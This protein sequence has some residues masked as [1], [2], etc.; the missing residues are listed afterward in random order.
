M[1]N[2]FETP[3]KAKIRDRLFQI[4]LETLQ[5]QGWK[6]ERIP[7]IGKSSV[8]RITKAGKS[9][10]VSIRT[11]Q[12]T[13]IAFPRNHADKGWETLSDVDL[14]LAVSVDDRHAPKFGQAHLIEADEM[15]Q[16][17]DRAYRAR[18]AQGYKIPLGRGVWLSLYHP[19]STDPVTHVGGGIGL[20]HPPIARVPLEPEE[21]A[22]DVI[23]KMTEAANGHERLTI[24]EAKRRL[25][26]ALGVDPSNIKITVEA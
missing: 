18:K 17:F 4:G 10:K 1:T 8:R 25:A 9:R 3:E 2:V 21:P 14:V 23:A 26:M 19:D 11:T 13:W 6:V 15:R 20:D 22:S 16:R 7:G 5:Q 12:D 24:A